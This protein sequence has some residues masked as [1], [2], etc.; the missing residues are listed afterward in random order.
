MATQ[1]TPS[2]NSVGRAWAALALKLSEVGKS[3]TDA[4]EFWAKIEGTAEQGEFMTRMR[5]MAKPDRTAFVS[6]HPTA[7]RFLR[8]HNEHVRGGE[9]TAFFCWLGKVRKPASLCGYPLTPPHSNL[10]ALEHDPLT[11]N[12]QNQL[13]PR[14]RLRLLSPRLRTP[15]PQHLPPPSL[16]FLLPPLPLLRRRRPRLASQRHP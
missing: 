3:S 12:R 9:P 13:K 2:R 6:A 8:D 11:L 14:S 4:K 16:S 15:S 5:E 1:P 10:T 7:S